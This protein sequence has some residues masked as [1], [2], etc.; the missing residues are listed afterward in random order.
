[1]KAEETQRRK[2]TKLKKKTFFLKNTR[3]DDGH[4]ESVCL[5]VCLF[6]CVY[7]GI[8]VFCSSMTIYQLL[9]TRR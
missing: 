8:F 5:L 1:M 3:S 9:D 7:V 6:V 2:A 4:F